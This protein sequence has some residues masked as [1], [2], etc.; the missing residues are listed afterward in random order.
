M[1]AMTRLRDGSAKGSTAFERLG[2]GW[3]EDGSAED[4]RSRSD[5]NL[6]A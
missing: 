5:S 1:L 3:R 6:R 4:D 2:V